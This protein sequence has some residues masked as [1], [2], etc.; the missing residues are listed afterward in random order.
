M[1]F[2]QEMKVEDYL[3][4]L[5]EFVLD[6][7]NEEVKE[8]LQS[9]LNQLE[10]FM[11]DEEI[12]DLD[13][14]IQVPISQQPMETMDISIELLRGMKAEDHFISVF[15]TT[16]DPRTKSLNVFMTISPK[17]PEGSEDWD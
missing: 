1:T 15:E 9:A 8:E 7:T 17:P 5:N 6:T 10:E 13:K 4:R 12:K 16:M 2:R 11:T 14:Y 3:I